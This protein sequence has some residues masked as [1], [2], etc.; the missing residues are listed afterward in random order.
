MNK[1]TKKLAMENQ[2]KTIRL[3]DGLELAEMIMELG[4]DGLEIND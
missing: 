3:I 1:E 2:D 4:V